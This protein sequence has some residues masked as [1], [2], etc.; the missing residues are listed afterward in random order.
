MRS[1]H[2]P[3]EDTSRQDLAAPSGD[4]LEDVLERFREIEA[5]PAARALVAQ[6]LAATLM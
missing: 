1:A 2:H 5:S 6:V 3:G 4:V